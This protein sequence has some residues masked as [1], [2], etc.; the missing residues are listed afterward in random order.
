[1]AEEYLNASYQGGG[2]AAIRSLTVTDGQVTGAG[3]W[4]ILSFVENHS[5]EYA[6]A[7]DAG[8]G[9]SKIEG[10]NSNGVKVQYPQETKVL[11]GLTGNEV[12]G[13]SSGNSDKTA[14]TSL[15]TKPSIVKQLADMRDGY[16]ETCIPHGYT[17]SG[18]VGVYYQVGK[19]TS[20][21]KVQGQG[22]TLQNVPVEVTGASVSADTAGDTALAAGPGAITPLGGAEVTPAAPTDVEELKSGAIHAVVTGGS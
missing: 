4:L 1:M 14:F 16:V 5:P 18:E 19:I 20:S 13:G 6:P 7:A 3:S 11:D 15:E 12:V 2:W 8:G 21:I 17:P 10:S 22:N 9:D